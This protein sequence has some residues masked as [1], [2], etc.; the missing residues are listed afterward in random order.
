M[1]TPERRASG[2][3]EL[4]GDG[5]AGGSNAGGK[6]DARGDRRPARPVA[7]EARD[8][9]PLAATYHQP[10]ERVAA[11]GS[12]GGW[13]A[14][15]VS[16]DEGVSP[17]VDAREPSASGASA[18]ADVPALG[19]EP[20]RGAVLL[21]PA[22]AV[23]R[24]FYDAYASWLAARGFAVLAPDVRGIGG[25]RPPE[26]T[27]L[28]DDL[29]DVARADLPAGLDW[30]EEHHPGAPLLYVGH[31]L[32]GQLLGVLPDPNRVD[33]A[34]L[35]ATA[36]AHWRLWEGLDRLKLMSLWWILIPV[37]TR[38][39]GYF[40]SR[41]VGLGEDL[42]PG[43]ARS[44]ARW[45]RHRGYVVDDDGRPIREGYRSYGGRIRAYSFPDDEMA[46]GGPAEEMLGWYRSADVEHRRPTPEELGR[47]RIGHFGFFREE[48][49]RDLWPESAAWLAGEADQGS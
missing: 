42:P 25:S 44:W 33:A 19:A 28:E 32:G 9:Y 6:V 31:S 29:L 41:L 45:G 39:Y 4:A 20:P 46:P 14:G 34:I 26:L 40:P 36:N 5:P 35:V 16:R 1:T 47:A 8:G 43:I 38:L 10:P 2:A 49:R 17:G 23:R 3:R 12:A 13:D 30:L 37:L 11:A 22:M 15:G 7:L 18:S 21:A 24:G 27:A 48:S